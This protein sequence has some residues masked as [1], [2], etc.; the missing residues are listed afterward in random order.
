MVKISYELFSFSYNAHCAL[1]KVFEIRPPVYP[2]ETPPVNRAGLSERGPAPWPW[3]CP[4]DEPRA[5]RLRSGAEGI[6]DG[7][8]RTVGERV[9][10]FLTAAKEAIFWR[11]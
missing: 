8:V 9:T 6:P 11:G 1:W 2:F 7:R 5:A 4:C 3:S 10:A